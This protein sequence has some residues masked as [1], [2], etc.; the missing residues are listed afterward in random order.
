MGSDLR[1]FFAVFPVFPQ[2]GPFL[3]AKHEQ[4]E[5]RRAPP[6]SPRSLRIWGSTRSPKNTG[7]VPILL[8]SLNPELP[9]PG[10]LLRRVPALPPDDH[11]GHE[12]VGTGIP[13]S[14]GEILPQN[15]TFHPERAQI[16]HFFSPQSRFSLFSPQC[17]LPACPGAVAPGRLPRFRVSAAAL[18][19]PGPAQGGQSGTDPRIPL[20]P[21][22]MSSQEI[23]PR[24]GK[25]QLRFGVKSPF[26][27][28]RQRFP[29]AASQGTKDLGLEFRSSQ[30]P[31]R[32]ILGLNSLI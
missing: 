27:P 25:A 7:I 8:F 14:H 30:R 12:E 1:W 15:A 29:A 22:K 13:H 18:P 32:P 19:L 16:S 9:A 3:D 21:P 26:F 10:L 4:V 5:V 31:S 6:R 24:P 20:F 17:W 11:R 28:T 2:F 23:L